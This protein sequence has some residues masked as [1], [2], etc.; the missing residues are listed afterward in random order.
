M[1][2]ANAAI[3]EAWNGVL[4]DKFSRFQF[5][6]TEGVSAHG[7]A[8]MDA[9]APAP[10][11]QVIDLGCG[12]GD[13]TIELARR[14]GGA[15]GVDAAS[16]FI[17]ASRAE[18]A[19]AGVDGVR[20]AVQDVQV[21]DLGGPYD[22]AFSRFG[23]LFFTSPVAALRN[24][25]ASLRPG[26]RLSMVVWRRREDNPWVHDAE[27]AVRQLIEERSDSGEPTCGPGPFSM[28]DAD[29]TSTVLTEA[30]YARVAFERHDADICIGRD[31]DE[32]VEFAVALGPAGEIIRLAGDDGQRRLPEVRAL[33]ADVLGRYLRDDGVW[34]PSSTWIVS[35]TRP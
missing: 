6:F 7:L 16:R 20:F 10:G 1:P 24:V 25:A 31:L 33:L 35:A 11:S 28:A 8:A 22:L 27:V 2:S 30:G 4:F 34:A 13:A 12:F 18:A 26:G 23:T 15:V 29:A 21:D 19:K 3:I 5:L 9:E 14:V 32:A 17:D